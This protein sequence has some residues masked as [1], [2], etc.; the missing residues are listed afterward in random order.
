[1]VSSYNN[2]GDN[3]DVQR[4]GLLGFDGKVENEKI[5]EVPNNLE[6]SL[7]PKPISKNLRY[8]NKRIYQ[9]S[10]EIDKIILFSND[11]NEMKIFEEI[12]KN[13]SD[14]Q[15]SF[16]ITNPIGFGKILKEKLYLNNFEKSF[17]LILT[18]NF[19]KFIL[20]NIES[21]K[22]KEFIDSFE[23]ESLE[24]HFTTED[25]PIDDKLENYKDIVKVVEKSYQELVVDNRKYDILLSIRKSFN[26]DFSKVRQLL[27]D[28]TNLKICFLDSNKNEKFRDQEGI[29]FFV[30]GENRKGLVYKHSHSHSEEHECDDEG[31][32]SNHNHKCDDEECEIN[33]N[34]HE[35][36]DEEC[37]DD[38]EDSCEDEGCQS[39]EFFSLHFFEFLNKNLTQ[40]FELSKIEEEILDYEEMINNFQKG[41]NYFNIYENDIQIIVDDKSDEELVE[42]Y[43]NNKTFKLFVAMKE[44]LDLIFPQ[45]DKMIIEKSPIFHNLGK[46]EIKEINNK[47]K[48]FFVEIIDNF[49]KNQ[50]IAE[51][52]KFE[53][54]KNVL[55]IES[56]EEFSDILKNNKDKL[57]VIDF[58]ADWCGKSKFL[59]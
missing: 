47:F 17:I 40:K 33:H 31:C 59:I 32:E 53:K 25:R 48:E 3:I 20:N 5:I 1:M 41:M 13:Y 43:Q 21:E 54:L 9:M 26:N 10:E 37:E 28:N 23:N 55:E 42:K 19:E 45:I 38:H 50:K 56:V 24:M 8:L 58:F 34:E 16:F 44:K 52:I 22:L 11:E 18:A 29:Y 7:F 36:E 49:Y 30:S 14:L 35:C 2:G 27:K 4:I 51:F 39:E 12:S 46:E 57:I 6:L 15:L